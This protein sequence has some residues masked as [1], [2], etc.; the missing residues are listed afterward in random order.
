VDCKLLVLKWI[1]ELLIHADSTSYLNIILLSQEMINIVHI[2]VH[3]ALKR[4]EIVLFQGIVRIL[5][6]VLGNSTFCQSE[7]ILYSNYMRCSDDLFFMKSNKN[8]TEEL[9]LLLPLRMCDNS[10]L[11]KLTFMHHFNLGLLE[12]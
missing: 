11:W 6:V 3:V 2:L 1:H 5:N 9:F 4:H 8:I 7:V 10:I 12:L